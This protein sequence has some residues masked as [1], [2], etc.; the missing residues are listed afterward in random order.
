[1]RTSEAILWL[2]ALFTGV[3]TA[4]ALTVRY[5]PSPDYALLR[6][7]FWAIA[8]GMWIFAIVWNVTAIQSAW[9]RIPVTAAIVMVA[10]VLLAEGVR[11]TYRNELVAAK[12]Q[13]GPLAG[14]TNSQL[15]ER[16][17]SFAQSLLALENSSQQERNRLMAEHFAKSR[18]LQ[19]REE[20]TAE[21]ESFNAQITLL[22][23]QQ[24]AEFHSKYRPDA[25]I[26]YEELQRRLGSLPD[27]PATTVIGRSTTMIG[28]NVLEGSNLAGPYPLATAAGL[29]EYWASRLP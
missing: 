13:T 24:T 16:T 3:T 25:V 17:I 15:R 11:W 19:S 27:P 12:S 4:W 5:L 29:L 22:Y 8:T 6:R 18:L 21:F 23:Q 14:L 2:D 10:G 26:L 9:V 28:R 7:L 1:M 20:Q